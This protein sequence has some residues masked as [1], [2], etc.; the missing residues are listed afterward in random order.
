MKPHL[1]YCS[2]DGIYTLP[3]YDVLAVQILQCQGDLS[4]VELGAFLVKRPHLPDKVQQLAT[5]GKT[6]AEI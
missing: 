2:V 3:V 4:R 6:E 5:L 1:Y